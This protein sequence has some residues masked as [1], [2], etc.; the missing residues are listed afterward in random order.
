VS[1]PSP[2]KTSPRR[3]LTS[4]QADYNAAHAHL[5]AGRVSEARAVFATLAAP[6]ANHRFVDNAMYWGGYCEAQ[7]GQHRKALEVWQA[8]IARD[9]KSPKVPDALFG[10]AQSHEALS[11][12]ALAET[13]YVEIVTQFPQAERQVDA[14]AALARLRR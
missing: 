13:Y 2:V 1:R 10:L 11:E 12:P 8:L 14:Q 3:E 5:K 6:G 7:L 4:V 9:P